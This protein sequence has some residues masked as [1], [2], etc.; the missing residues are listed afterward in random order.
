MQIVELETT[1]DEIFRSATGDH[2]AKSRDVIC[3]ALRWVLC[4]FRSFTAREHAFASSISPDGT[5]REGVS[6]DFIL[7][8]CAHLLVERQYVGVGFVHL[9]VPDSSRM[10]APSLFSLSKAHVVAAVS[11]LLLESSIGSSEFLTARASFSD[12]SSLGLQHRLQSPEKR[13]QDGKSHTGEFF[14][15]YAS[16]YCPRHCREA[17]DDSRL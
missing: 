14:K 3:I 5:F 8:I 11:C 15:D 12:P 1:Y 17:E 9:S 13:P 4:S 16:Q 2:K 6:K 10:T 7:A